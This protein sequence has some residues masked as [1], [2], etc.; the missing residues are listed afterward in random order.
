[1]FGG[2]CFMIHGNM[3]GGV[4]RADLIVRVRAEKF[5]PA[6]KQPNTRAFD[7]TGKPMKGFVVVTPKGYRTDTSFKN[8]VALGIECARARPRKIKKIRPRLK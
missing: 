6:I 7:F 4:L 3:C 8:W 1:M 2:I 5:E